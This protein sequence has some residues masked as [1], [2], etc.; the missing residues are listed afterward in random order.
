MVQCNHDVC[1]DAFNSR[2]KITKKR[3]MGGVGIIILNIIENNYAILLGK[4]KFGKYK[5]EYNVC[6]GHVENYDNECYINAAKRELY[7]EFKINAKNRF[8]FDLIFKNSSGNLNYI[9]DENGSLFLIGFINDANIKISNLNL[10]ILNDKYSTKIMAYKEITNL[11]YF[12]LNTKTN[13]NGNRLKISSL[14]ESLID[15]IKNENI[16]FE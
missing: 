14:A 7:E 10:T 8:T 13:I 3:T 15:K 5:N 4:E 12:W 1:I 16:I 9:I 11:D 2:K 6:T